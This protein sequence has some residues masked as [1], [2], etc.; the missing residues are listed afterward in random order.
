[1]G[2]R[3]PKAKGVEERFWSK[4]RK[5]DGCWEWTDALTKTGY[6]TLTIVVYVKDRRTVRAK[7]AHRV[8]WEINKGPIPDGLHVCH[9]CDNPQ[10]VRPEHLFLGTDADNLAD[11]VAKGRSNRGERHW[12][13]ALSFVAVR[14][15]RRLTRKLAIV[16][17]KRFGVREAT[18]RAVI[19]G[20]IWREA[21]SVGRAS[22]GTSSDPAQGRQ[23]EES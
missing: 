15:I 6:G 8:S 18:V 9:H 2:K 12:N 13:A 23:P 11:M 10:C 16:M 4:V 7:L 20:R 17:A 1:M 19:T 3:G 14:E 21:R 5:S 22:S